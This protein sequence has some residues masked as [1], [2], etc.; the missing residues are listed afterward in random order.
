MLFG[1]S[2]VRPAQVSVSGVNTLLQATILLR[3]V[4]LLEAVQHNYSHEDQSLKA[5][6]VAIAM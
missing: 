3:R 4:V 6:W 5:R 2:I 1:P